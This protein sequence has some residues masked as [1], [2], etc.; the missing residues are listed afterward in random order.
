MSLD[1]IISKLYLNLGVLKIANGCL[2]TRITDEVAIYFVF[3]IIVSL[4]DFLF[5]YINVFMVKKKNV[6]HEI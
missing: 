2:V 1:L 6:F 5:D 3:G 4:M